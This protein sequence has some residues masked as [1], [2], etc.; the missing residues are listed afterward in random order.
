MELAMRFENTN[1]DK[2]THPIALS[3]PL[4]K[5]PT[6]VSA[7][8]WLTNDRVAATATFC[9]KKPTRANKKIGKLNHWRS[10]SA[11]VCKPR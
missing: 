5:R 2:N 4:T 11:T 7:D 6:A 1:A 10:V 8:E 3:S 9:K